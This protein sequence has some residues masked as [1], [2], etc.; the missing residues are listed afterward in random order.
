MKKIMVVFLVVS[1]LVFSGCTTAPAVGPMAT[2]RIIEVKKSKDEIFVA[3]M[4]WIA[5]NFKSA[6]AVIEYQDK[7]AGKIVGNGSAHVSFAILPVDTRFTLTID[8]K[9]G[10]AKISIQNIYITS[11]VNGYTAR[12]NATPEMAGRFMQ[13]EGNKLFDSYAI[14]ITSKAAEW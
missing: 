14:A 2:E 12:N 7:E 10:K 4:D 5:K 6:K 11:T 1:G 13:L 3:S 9:E 8:V